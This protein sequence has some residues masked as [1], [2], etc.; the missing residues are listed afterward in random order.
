MPRDKVLIPKI[1]WIVEC[2]RGKGY[3][4]ISHRRSI[5][6]SDSDSCN[7]EDENPTQRGPKSELDRARD[8]ILE[9][10]VKHHFDGLLKVTIADEGSGLLANC[11]CQ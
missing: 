3:E 8:G 1:I 7:Q 10:R 2:S 11:R 9:K 5:E 4:L 6:Y